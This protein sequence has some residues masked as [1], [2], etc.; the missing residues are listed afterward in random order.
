MLNT[1]WTNLILFCQANLYKLL[2]GSEKGI[3]IK[4]VKG[5]FYVHD[6]FC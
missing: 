5:H 1:K 6:F 2:S 4:K 3:I